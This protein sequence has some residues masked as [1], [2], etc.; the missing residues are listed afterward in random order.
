MFGTFFCFERVFTVQNVMYISVCWARIWLRPMGRITG[1]GRVSGKLPDN[2]LGGP[3]GCTIH[4]LVNDDTSCFHNPYFD[5]GWPIGSEQ[6]CAR[7]TILTRNSVRNLNLTPDTRSF[8]LTLPYIS[9]VHSRIRYI[10]ISD[11]RYPMTTSFRWSRS[12]VHET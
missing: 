5:T 12:D 7:I 10:G 6:L 11:T 4:L 1:C 2:R 3:Q 9:S 8:D